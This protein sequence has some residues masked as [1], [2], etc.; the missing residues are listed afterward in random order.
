MKIETGE[1]NGILR[2]IAKKVEKIDDEIRDLAEKMR[3][4][5]AGDKNAVGLAAPQI[6]RSVRVIVATIGKNEIV[7]INPEIKSFSA[8]CETAEEGC[9]S[10]PGQFF[11]VSRA[12]KITVEFL[13]LDGQ[14]IILPLKDFDA[15]VVQHEIDHL[16]GVLFIDRISK[17][18]FE[19]SAAKMI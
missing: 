2:K 1:K 6:G 18:I 7:M 13:N 10:L 16:N 11:P 4:E 8:E 17:E 19:N 14:K 9:L 15:R 3:A 5:V 12:K